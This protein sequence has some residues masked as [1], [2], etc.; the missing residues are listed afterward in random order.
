MCGRLKLLYLPIRRKGTTSLSPSSTHRTLRVDGCGHGRT[1]RNK[2][3]LGHKPNPDR[4]KHWR[5]H[6]IIHSRNKP[7]CERSAH[8]RTR[9][10]QTQVP[11]P[12]ASILHV[13]C[14][15]SMQISVPTLS[16]DSIRG[17]HGIPEAMTLLS[18]VFDYGGLRSTT[19]GHNK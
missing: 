10:R 9:G 19:Q 12:K 3:T 7:S 4:A 13:H 14:P 2:C 6:A 17:F 8:H 15:H 5:T 16:K 1:G 18:I 11:A